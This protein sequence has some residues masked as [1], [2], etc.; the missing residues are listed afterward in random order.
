MRLLQLWPN[1]LQDYTTVLQWEKLAFW[2][3]KH[4]GLIWISENA[5]S[6]ILTDKQGW[7]VFVHFKCLWFNWNVF[8][9][10]DF[11]RLQCHTRSAG[12]FV[13]QKISGLVVA[14]GTSTISLWKM[15]NKTEIERESESTTLIKP[16][17]V[18]CHEKQ[19][20]NSL[21]WTNKQSW[22]AGGL[23]SLCKDR[24]PLLTAKYWHHI[25]Y[26]SVFRT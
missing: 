22:L 14:E 23:R 17:G 2:E 19:R 8:F 4:S 18:G 6:T 20:T 24:A 25:C 12:S 7:G 5:R 1:V 10:C 3:R 11:S 26:V 13:H 15:H 9:S 16:T 21:S